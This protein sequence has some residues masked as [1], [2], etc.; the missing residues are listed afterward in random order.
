MAAHYV[1]T[2]LL[3]PQQ[4]VYLAASACE[5]A[6]LALKGVWRFVPRSSGAQCVMMAGIL[7]ML[8]WCADN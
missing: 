1:V 4:I 5:V 3:F 2:L 6:L 8:V 7:T